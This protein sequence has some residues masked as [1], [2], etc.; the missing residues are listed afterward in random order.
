[1]LVDAVEKGKVAPTP[2]VERREILVLVLFAA[3]V[4][5]APQFFFPIILM[6]V[7]CFA[8]FACAYNLVFGYTGLLAF[9]H[10]AFYGSA[11]YATA[12]SAK[13]WGFPP[14]LAV[15]WGTFVAG[16]LGL[17]FGWLAVR[18]RG[19]YFA[20]ITLALAQLVYFY[21]L[22]APWAHAEDGIQQVPR[23]YLFGFID[24]SNMMALYM[25]VVGVFVIGFAIIYRAVHSP[26]GD[27]LRA[28]RENEPRAISLG[29]RADTYK[30]AAF[31]LSAAL[32]GL[33][34]GTKTIVFQLASL[35]DIYYTM[36]ADVL[37]MVLIGG[38]GTILGPV[39][40]A[41]I[42]VSAK[43]YLAVLGS[44]V[45][46]VEGTIFIACILS[47]R[48]GVVGTLARVYAR[49]RSAQNGCRNSAVF[50]AED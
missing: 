29:Y 2:V 38:I 9:G 31:T 18:R 49:L 35:V 30:I 10:A 17:V 19:L 1:M 36:S 14:E 41:A 40:G 22:K 4:V 6:K 13:V 42:M 48:Q 7:L 50:R 25:F 39:V 20:M 26:F 33:A 32:S 11:A 43:T 27:V 21:I 3:F 15:L 44:W 47:F 8:L 12:H 45:L 16:S 28:I 23:G 5:V 24:L 37:L 46:I 34:G